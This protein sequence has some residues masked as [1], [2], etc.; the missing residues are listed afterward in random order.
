MPLRTQSPKHTFAENIDQRIRQLQD[1]LATQP[2]AATRER[3]L[4]QI[5]ELETALHMEGWLRSPELRPPE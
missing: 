5:K 4:Q 2:D 3:L 1:E